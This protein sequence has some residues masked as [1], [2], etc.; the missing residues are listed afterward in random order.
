MKVK[1]EIPDWR[2]RFPFFPFSFFSFVAGY[3]FLKR[4]FSYECDWRRHY[5]VGGWLEVE[6]WKRGG[7]ASLVGFSV[8]VGQ[9][10]V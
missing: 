1:N 5:K 6:R 8:A 7:E 4:V 10:E 3:L 9:N 2:F